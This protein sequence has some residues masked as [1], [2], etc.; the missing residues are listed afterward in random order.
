MQKKFFFDWLKSF[1]LFLR[2]VFFDA[3]KVFFDGFPEDLP[4]V[5]TAEQSLHATSLWK[6]S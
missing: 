2:K 4:H 1:F 5:L 3:K 6:A